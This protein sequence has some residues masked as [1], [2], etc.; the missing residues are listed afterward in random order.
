MTIWLADVVAREERGWRKHP[1][2]SMAIAAASLIAGVVLIAFDISHAAGNV[3]LV[4]FLVE[5]GIWLTRVRGKPESSESS[6]SVGRAMWAE[7][8]RIW[9]ASIG[10]VTF[11][12]AA[13][14]LAFWLDRSYWGLT[15]GLFAVLLVTA[16]VA[17][18]VIAHFRPGAVQR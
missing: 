9:W 5:I 2:L 17:V 18:R 4:G 14:F 8:P 15:L 12:A 3:F 10:A 11:M 16:N 13:G 1:R 6:T 7:H